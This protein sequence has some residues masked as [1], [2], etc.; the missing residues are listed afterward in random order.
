MKNIL[1]ALLLCA[2]L[3]GA[4]YASNGMGNGKAYAKENERGYR[5]DKGNGNPNSG[6]TENEDEASDDSISTGNFDTAKQN[7]VQAREQW[8]E[9][10]EDKFEDRLEKGKQY[11]QNAISVLENM[12][13]VTE[14]NLQ[15]SRLSEQE[16]EQYMEQIRE[17]VRELEDLMNRVGNSTNAS[18]LIGNARHVKDEW[19]DSKEAARVAIGGIGVGRVDDALEAGYKAVAKT[20][21]LIAKCSAGGFDTS[22]AT[23]DLSLFS[24]QLRLA[25]EDNALA[26]GDF[27]STNSTNATSGY[28]HLQ[29]AHKHLVQAKKIAQD[30]KEDLKVCVQKK[31]HLTLIGDGWLT[32]SG[33][34]NAEISGNGTVSANFSSNTSLSKVLIVDRA[35]DIVVNFVGGNETG[36]T[37][38]MTS[39]T[40]VHIREFAGVGSISVS[41]SKYTITLSGEGISLY[42]QGMGIAILKGNGTYSAGARGNSTALL[43][44]SWSANGAAVRVSSRVNEWAN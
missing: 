44:G 27:N 41:G 42:A 6:E 43:N 29:D 20:E 10:K 14:K 18:E 17:R 16:K 13:K 32:A 38:N 12:L 23:S 21:E 40:Y 24:E 19:H 28:G 30:L 36:N 3:F 8:M 34:G 37:T 2:V 5:L 7:Y 33:S 4:V 39:A 22:K 26:Q 11:T 9:K 15:R 35:G 31:G 1:L 25:S